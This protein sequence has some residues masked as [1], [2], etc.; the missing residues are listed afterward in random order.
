[1]AA[2]QGARTGA[3]GEN[4]YRKIITLEGEFMRYVVLGF[5]L[6]ATACAGA[7]PSAPTASSSAI[8]GGAATEA[9]GGSA[10]P[11]KGTYEGLETVGTVPSNHHL[12]DVTGNATHLGRFTVT[13]D[14][15]IMTGG[16]IGTST[17]TAANGDEFSTSFTR[18]GVVVPPTITF[19][20][21][22]TITIGTGRFANAS[23]TFT[24]VQ[25]RGLSMPYNNSATIDG[26]I[27][28]GH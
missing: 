19:T 5:C 27:N 16:G 13:A 18:S 10:L 2:W 11:F 1:L 4:A 23:G 17:W 20:E 25:T 9:R 14:W 28:L 26:T 21:T 12:G 3:A 6:F 24:V 22:H 7:A 15:T 8:G